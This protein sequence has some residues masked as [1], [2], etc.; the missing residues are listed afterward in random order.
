LQGH[1]QVWRNATVKSGSYTNEGDAQDSQWKE[2]FFGSNY[3]ELASIK[4]KYD[5]DGVFWAIGG[6]GSDEW[7]VRDVDGGKR[8]RELLRRM[9]DCVMSI[10]DLNAR[11]YQGSRI[12]IRP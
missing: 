10:D 2:A 12:G 4:R 11:R 9:V 6:V 7:E 1:I 5:P 3:D 8:E